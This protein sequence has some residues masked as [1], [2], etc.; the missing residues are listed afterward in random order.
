M[1]KLTYQLSDKIILVAGHAS[2]LSQGIIKSFLREGATVITPAMCLQ[3]ITDL[4]QYVDTITTGHLITQLLDVPDCVQAAAFT[5]TI[6]EK[7]GRIDI[8]VSTIECTDNTDWLTEVDMEV[9]QKMLDDDINLFFLCARLTLP[10]LRKT[11]DALFVSVCNSHFQEPEKQY[12]LAALA[13]SARTSMSRLF[14]REAKQHN[15]RYYHLQVQ[16]RD[17]T[18]VLAAKEPPLLLSDYDSIG[19]HI[20]QLYTE[21]A[22]KTE[23]VF[24]FFPPLSYS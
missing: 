12:G 14:S 21:P 8:V 20:I 2:R 11:P 1:Q 4:K 23:L 6:L 17:S 24:Q 7:F 10:L 5:E 18:Q 22:E 9:W 3:E 19:D 13:D 16:Q 15:T